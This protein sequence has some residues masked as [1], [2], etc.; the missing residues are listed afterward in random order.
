MPED[1][2]IHS[3]YPFDR[4]FHKCPPELLNRLCGRLGYDHDEARNA[5]I[6]LLRFLTVCSKSERSLA[7]SKRIDEIWHEVILY[8]REYATICSEVCGHFIH[9]IPTAERDP[10]AYERTLASLKTAF[11][12]L[13][14][15]YWPYGEPNFAD[16]SA[17]S[18]CGGTCSN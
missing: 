7:P 9:H 15:E 8:T 3:E 13:N 17:C 1:N 6:E 18:D 14:S 2:M 11:G 5:W 12:S 16:C 10:E 4:S